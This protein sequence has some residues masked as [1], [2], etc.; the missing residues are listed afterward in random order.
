T[1]ATR[2]FQRVTIPA[3]PRLAS[4]NH[5][6]LPASTGRRPRRCR[7]SSTERGVRRE[8]ILP[9]DT[10]RNLEDGDIGLQATFSCVIPLTR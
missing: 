3:I 4:V 9:G 2:C 8:S 7:A 6:A 10:T 1:A 5:S